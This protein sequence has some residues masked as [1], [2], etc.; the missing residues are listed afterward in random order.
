MYFIYFIPYNVLNIRICIILKG[1]EANLH[2]SHTP[3]C[4]VI[5]FCFLSE[6]MVFF[7]FDIKFDLI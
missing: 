4:I 6:W 7:A 1:L 2:Y 3:S 5:S